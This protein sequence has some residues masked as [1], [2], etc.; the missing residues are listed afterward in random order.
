MRLKLGMSLALVSAIPLTMATGASAAAP[1]YGAQCNAAWS[2]KRGTHDYRVYKKACVT[3]APA[4]TQ[5]ARSAGNNDDDDANASRAV[6]AC[7]A[8]SPPPR[9]RT[10]NTWAAYDACVS[11]AVAAQ[12]A[13]GGRRLTATLPGV[14]GD[15]TDQD[16]S[17]TAAPAVDKGHGKPAN[18]PSVTKG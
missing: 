15:P 6:A 4:A 12:K 10:E 17:G 5:A 16:G 1:Q 13:Y 9:R 2:G 18:K 8:Q 7:R 14:S 3:A 11:A